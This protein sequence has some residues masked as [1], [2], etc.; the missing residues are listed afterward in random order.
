MQL[1]AERRTE[2]GKKTKKIRQKRKIPSVI[3]GK[4]I[5]SIPIT[6]NLNEF[7]KTF[8][9]AGETTLIDVNV[10]KDSYAVLVTD[11][12]YDPVYDVPVHACF[13]KVDL[14][15]KIS[16]EV[17]VKVVGEENSS[18]LKSGQGLLLTL[19][20]EVEVEALPADLP[21]EFIIDVSHLEEI[22]QFLTVGELNYDRK[23][24]SIPGFEDD[25]PVVR[26]DYAE[27]LEEEEE[28]TEEE[29]LE[30][31]EATE[32]LSE[33]EIAAREEENEGEK[34]ETKKE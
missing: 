5:E 23:K 12:Q 26:V 25:E 15:E 21:H 33:E 6:L 32:E 11:V 18:V 20:S 9:E 30:G 31:V 29:L 19:L 4:G 22:G 10:D 8:S 13:H 7:T 24:V 14:T 3:F 17:P 2:F 28:V 16:A 1:T 34:V 27:M